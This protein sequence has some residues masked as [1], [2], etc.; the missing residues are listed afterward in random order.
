MS[1]SASAQLQVSHIFLQCT[2][3]GTVSKDFLLQVFFTNHLPPKPL[4]ITLGSFQIF[5]KVRGDI[6]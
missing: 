2:F 4:K 6:R 5:L 3:K 1:K